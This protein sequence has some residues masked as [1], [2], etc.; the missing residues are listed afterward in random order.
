VDQNQGSILAAY[1]AQKRPASPSPQR[2]N[3]LNITCA[4]IEEPSFAISDGRI[5]DVGESTREKNKECPRLSYLIPNFCG[6]DIEYPPKSICQRLGYLCGGMQSCFR[7]L[8]G[9]A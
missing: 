7:P 9:R 1:S 4:I 5:E 8:R 2:I 3:T 6:L